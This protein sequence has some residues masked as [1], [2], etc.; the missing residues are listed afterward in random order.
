MLRL[1][2]RDRR[3]VAKCAAAQWLTTSQVRQLF[4]R[5]AT[6]DAVRRRL[7]ALDE[8]GYLVAEQRAFQES[9]YAVGP[10][11][12][13]ILT[14][15]L[16]EVARPRVPQRL[17]HVIAVNDLRVAVESGARPVRFF[18]AYWELARLGWEYPVIPDAAFSFERQGTE[19]FM[20]EYD[21]GTESPTVILQK[22][23]RYGSL[24]PLFPFDAVM[25]LTATDEA[26]VSLCKILAPQAKDSM[27]LVGCLED[28]RVLSLWG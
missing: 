4:F 13:E 17:R 11:A 23:P 26:R 3:I 22:L 16:T 20:A 10:R 8:A 24:L 28:V 9:I 1:T 19:T 27:L 12:R 25:F 15:G 21:R 5:D 2:S 7:R 6:A 14:G 18:F